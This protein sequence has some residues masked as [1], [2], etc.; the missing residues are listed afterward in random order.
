VHHPSNPISPFPIRGD[1][2]QG[3]H[4]GLFLPDRIGA[5]RPFGGDSLSIGLFCGTLFI[6]LPC[7]IGRFS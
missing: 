6:P 1:S 2:V 3:S 7:R 4:S 5:A